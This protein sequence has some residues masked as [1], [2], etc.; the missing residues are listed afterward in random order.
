MEEIKPDILVVL[1]AYNCADTIVEAGMCILRQSYKNIKLM[2]LDDGSTDTTYHEAKK[3]L[4]YYDSLGWKP[5]HPVTVATHSPNI[6]IVDTLNYGLLIAM[7]NDI[8]YVARMDGD[9]LCS[10]CRLEKQLNYMVEK[11]LD[12]CGTWARVVG[13][14]GKHLEDFHPMIPEGDEKKWLVKFNYFIHGSMMINTSILKK[15]GCYTDVRHMIEDFDLWMR[16]ADQGRVGILKEYMY[17]LVRGNSTTSGHENEIY[18]KAKEIRLF[19][20]KM[21]GIQIPDHDLPNFNTIRS[22]N[23]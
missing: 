21:W 2:V 20:A 17:T 3:L 11:D 13:K 14:D 15:V 18:N 10:P 1:P 23:V 22:N 7:K 12:L 19:W 5:K 6:G 9:D 16:I 8:P 4:Y